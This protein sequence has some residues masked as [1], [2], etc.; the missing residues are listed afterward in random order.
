MPRRRQPTTDAARTTNDTSAPIS[1]S[2]RGLRQRRAHHQRS[3]GVGMKR[4]LCLRTAPGRPVAIARWHPNPARPR[5]GTHHQA[6]AA[7]NIL[8]SPQLATNL[9]VQF[10][11]GEADLVVDLGAELQRYIQA[12]GFAVRSTGGQHDWPPTAAAIS[13]GRPDPPPTRTA[14]SGARAATCRRRS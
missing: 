5:T 6:R 2:C 13:A 9:Q 11:R 3:A 7:T 10:Q 1:R 4:R 8:G 12:A 14:T